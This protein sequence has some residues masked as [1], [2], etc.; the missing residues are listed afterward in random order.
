MSEEK[1]FVCPVCGL[2]YRDEETARECEKFCTANDM[3]S[4][5]IAKNAIEYSSKEKEPVDES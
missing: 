4:L 5:T 2:H 3:C 1:T